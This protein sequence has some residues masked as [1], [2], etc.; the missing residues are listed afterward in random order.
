[1]K[2]AIFGLVMVMVAFTV[3]GSEKEG[4]T[5]KDAKNEALVALSGTVSDSGSGESLVGVEVKIEGTEE[6][7][8]TDFDGNF[9][10]SNVKPGEYKL[11]A[12]YI[13]YQ[14]STET[15]EVNGNDKQVTIK[16]ENSK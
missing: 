5:S 4:K 12:N 11:T 9:V 16:M 10:F 1:M 14:K 6:K 15:L 13:S 2:K 3:T 7:T 8:Y